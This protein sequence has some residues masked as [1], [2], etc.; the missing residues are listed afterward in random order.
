LTFS[1]LFQVPF[2]ELDLAP[3]ISFGSSKP[4]NIGAGFDRNLNDI[5]NDRPSF[6][7][8]IGRPEWRR[9]GSA[10]ADDVKSALILAPIGSSGNLA[11]NYGLGPGTRTINLRAS[12]T[13]EVRDRFRLRPS[14]DLFNIFNNT[15]FSFGSEFI[16]RDDSDFLIPRRTQRP[17]TVLLSLKVMF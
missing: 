11:R 5:E 15:I 1:G 8:G 9:P 14:I 4:F 17:R 16:D 3:V 6:I 13:F 2:V 12:R 7:T 10:P